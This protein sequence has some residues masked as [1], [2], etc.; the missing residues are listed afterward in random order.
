MRIKEVSDDKRLFINMAA[1]I[2]AF[3]VSLGISF[4]LTPY[5]V[6]R[7]G[8]EAYGFVG[9][10]NNFVSYA[11]IIVT[12]LNSMSAR[13]ITISIHQEDYESANQYFSSVV[14]ANILITAVLLVPTVVVICLLERIINV[15][16]ALLSDVRMLWILIFA[17]SLLGIVTSVFGIATYVR[18]RLDLASVRII[19]SELI[20]A[21]ILCFCFFLLPAHVYYIGLASAVTRVYLIASSIYLTRMLLPEIRIR[22]SYFRWGKIKELLS[23]GVWNS[24]TRIGSILSNELDLLITNLFVGAVAM[25]VVS[26][27]KQLPALILSVFGMLAGVFMP[28][29]NISYAK[30]DYDDI[31]QQLLFSVKL[32]GMVACIPVACVYAFGDTFFHLWVPGE[33]A[34]LLQGLAIVGSLAFPISLSLEPLWNI[35]TVTNK[36]RQSSLFLISNAFAT[37]LMV[38]ILLH[39]TDDDV[40]KMY[41]V[42]GTSSI[43]SVIRSLTFL[44]LY[45][46]KCV[47]LKLTIFY[48]P[49]LKNL[50]ALV[51]VTAFAFGLRYY[52]QASTWIGFFTLCGATGVIALGVNYFILLNRDDR[53]LLH[54]KIR[55]RLRRKEANE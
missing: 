32:L 47:K 14:F 23:S 39:F 40:A 16:T 49:I 18:N 5:I 6:E 2:T 46:A 30:G 41:I 31:R 53:A 34:R 51:V 9:L 24:V 13:F 26:V 43:F 3:V 48:G 17:D 28:Q 54:Q 20:R 35:F 15:P 25:G 19:E 38:F 4:F 36:I 45:G 44:P 21:G 29:L 7:L 27:A 10:A 1:Q 8:A 55:N 50:L 37:V 42:V 22:R 52:F 33:D 11:Q 12:A